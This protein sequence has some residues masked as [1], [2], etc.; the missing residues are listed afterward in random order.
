MDY[1]QLYFSDS[2]KNIIESENF[3]KEA[4]VAP[5]YPKYH[6]GLFNLFTSKNKKLKDD[7]EIDILKNFKNE[8]E[9]NILFLIREIKTLEEIIEK[10]KITGEK[11]NNLK[12]LQTVLANMEDSDRNDLHKLFKLLIEKID[13]VNRDPLIFNIY[14][15]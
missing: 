2:F 11:E 7:Y 5:N 12:I 15:K 13:F 6:T 3:E 9:P 8:L 10:Q 1:P 4:P 14:I